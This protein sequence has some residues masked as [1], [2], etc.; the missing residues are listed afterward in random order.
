MVWD[1]Y[2]PHHPHHLL[3]RDFMKIYI[4]LLVLLLLILIF[5]AFSPFVQ[6]QISKGTIIS[7]GNALDSG[8][9]EKAKRYFLN[10]AS[11]TTEAEANLYTDA[12]NKLQGKINDGAFK[13]Y[14]YVHDVETFSLTNAKIAFI[15]WFTIN[16]KS[17]EVNGM[18]ELVRT[19]I[20]SWKIKKM[21]SND[22]AFKYAFFE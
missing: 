8:K 15:A 6:K 18:M 1:K 12:F 5:T 13:G 14:M 3:E 21:S 9:V 22:T 20:W 19:G 2:L 17:N 11:V 7:L 10:N 4:C 16:N